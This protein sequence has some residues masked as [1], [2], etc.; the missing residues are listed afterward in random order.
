M[1]IRSNYENAATLLLFIVN[2]RQIDSITIK[3]AVD[4]IDSYN[5]FLAANPD[6]EN[7]T[8]KVIDI[9]TMQTAESVISHAESLMLL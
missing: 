6:D 7:D 2:T 3:E 9:N 8:S 1:T 4:I 5:D